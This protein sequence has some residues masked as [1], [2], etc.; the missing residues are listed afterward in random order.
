MTISAADS[1]SFKRNRWTHGLVTSAELQQTAQRGEPLALVVDQ[2][3]VLLEDRVLP[4]AGGVLQLEH[5]VR[6]EQVV[7]AL[8]AP[9]VF[10]ADLEFAV[11]AL[12][13]PIQ[14]GQRVAGGDVVGDV[15]EVDAADGTAA[16][17]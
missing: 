8:A 10:T 6:V 12:V 2:L 13:G 3:G 14:V 11:R 7:L 15:V 1:T 16:A 4:G 9:L 5:G 17:R